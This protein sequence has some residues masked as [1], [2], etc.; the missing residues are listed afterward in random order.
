MK[1]LKLAWGI[2]TTWLRHYRW[3]SYPSYMG[4]AQR[5]EFLTE[6]P[7][8]EQVGGRG[9]QLRERYARYVET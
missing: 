7:I 8:L 4:E 1:A 2:S 6:Q 3:S 9:R 5:P